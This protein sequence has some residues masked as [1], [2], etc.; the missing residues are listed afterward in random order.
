MTDEV[1]ASQ[2]ILL[3]VWLLQGENPLWHLHSLTCC[4]VST[5]EPRAWEHGLFLFYI[6]FKGLKGVL[7]GSFLHVIL[8]RL[9]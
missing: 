8:T 2:V 6:S 3:S 7:H 9:D 4:S 1:S 5:A